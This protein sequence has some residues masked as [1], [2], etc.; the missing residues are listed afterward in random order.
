MRRL[1][2]AGVALLVIPALAF[3]GAT[4][5]DG[6]D[7]LKI[8]AKMDPAKASKRKSLPRPVELRFDY[9]AG[10]TDDSR[11]ADVRSVSIFT[12]GVVSA[13]D[14]FPKC[15]ET[16]LV[17]EG[18]S[19]CPR[20]SR[21]GKGTA[22]AEVHPPDSATSKVNITVPVQI[23]NGKLETDRDGEPT[24][25]PPKDG[26][27]FYTKIGDTRVALPFWAENNDTRVTLYNT[28]EDETPPADN[29]LFTVKEV[30]VVF[31]RRSVRRNGKR[32]PWMAAPSKCPDDRTWT[33]TAT[34]DRY[35]GGEITASHDIRCKKA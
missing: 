24:L 29:S 8:R 17:D 13:Y 3:A 34:T 28:E 25:D 23:F 1:T 6:T 31:P 2:L 35:E 32:V 16:D 5:T 19:A 30:H 26:I 20:G 22:I 12:G 7:T 18:T 27:I 33:V 10:T 15:D 9:I 14:S 4:V 11:L 21:V